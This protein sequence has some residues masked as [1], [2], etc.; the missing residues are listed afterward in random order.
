M[1]WCLPRSLIRSRTA[2]IWFGIEADGRLVEDEQIGI[3]HHGIG[4]ADALAVAFGKRADDLVFDV[5]EAAKLLHRL[6][7]LLDFAAA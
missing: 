2:R 6:D 5:L 7:A 1:V 4:Q 3:V